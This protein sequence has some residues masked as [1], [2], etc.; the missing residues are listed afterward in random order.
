MS[1]MPEV[2]PVSQLRGNHKKIFSQ[3]QKGPVILAQRSRSAAVLVSIEDWNEREKRI[4][5]L[6]AQLRL[7][8]AAKEARAVMERMASGEERSYS[9]EEL[10][11]EIRKRHGDHVADQL[12]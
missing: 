10:I 12:L 8:E 4:E 6:E 11:T 3:I 2:V 1:A 7:Y 9:H 5:K